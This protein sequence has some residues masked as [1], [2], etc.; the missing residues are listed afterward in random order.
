ML[1]KCQFPPP[2]LSSSDG[3]PVGEKVWDWYIQEQLLQNF[4]PIWPH[5][6]SCRQDHI[7][8][9]TREPRTGSQTWGS[10]GEKRYNW[11]ALPPSCLHAQAFLVV[12]ILCKKW[13]N[14]DRLANHNMSQGFTTPITST[15]HSGPKSCT[16][17]RHLAMGLW[18]Q[19]ANTM[20]GVSVRSSLI[21]ASIP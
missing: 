20:Q 5:F 4:L 18:L 11:V 21:N 9:Y 16:L 13:R 15:S 3:F 8:G 17:Q 10:F 1:I 7:Q 12:F 2:F 6:G 14:P 19:V